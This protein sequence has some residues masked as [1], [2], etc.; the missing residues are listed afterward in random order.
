MIDRVGMDYLFIS[1]LQKER[2]QIF[3]VKCS[4]MR[5][6]GGVIYVLIRQL[7]VVAS[8]KT[9]IVWNFF[10]CNPISQRMCFAVHV[11]RYIDDAN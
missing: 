4:L 3:E 1:H 11:K 7:S 5:Y 9:M 8:V 2:G 10:L 6:N